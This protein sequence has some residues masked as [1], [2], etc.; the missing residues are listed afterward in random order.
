MSDRVLPFSTA[1]Q[2]YGTTR[3]L[4]VRAVPQ[5]RTQAQGAQASPQA[6]QVAKPA[7]HDTFDFSAA[8]RARST[9]SHPLAAA[10][11][12]GQ[13]SFEGSAATAATTPPPAPQA[14]TQVAGSMPIYTNPAS[15]NVAATGV[16][17]GRLI[18]FEA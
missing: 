6:V 10:K 12:P 8:A 2:A 16:D 4:M 7:Q 1:A 9:P 15:R 3:P 18:D 13:V 14:R 17:A 11:V 5:G